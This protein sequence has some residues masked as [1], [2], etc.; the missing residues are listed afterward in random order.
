MNQALQAPFNLVISSILSSIVYVGNLIQNCTFCSFSVLNCLFFRSTGVLFLRQLAFF[1]LLNFFL[2]GNFRCHQGKS[3]IA[4]THMYSVLNPSH[5][6]DL[7]ET[8]LGYFPKMSL[9]FI[10]L[11]VEEPELVPIS[12]PALYPV[13]VHGT[14]FKAW[15]N[16]QKEVVFNIL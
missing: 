3:Y 10:E 8:K 12:N 2:Q 5:I 16:I 11:Q 13:V 15:E 7:I 4:P 6:Q 14:Y 9:F 1:T